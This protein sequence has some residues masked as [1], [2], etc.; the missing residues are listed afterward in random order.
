MVLY[1]MEA[2]IFYILKLK[3]EVGQR[4]LLSAGKSKE[5]KG[6]K[7]NQ[8]INKK[9]G[10]IFILF[11]WLFAESVMHLDKKDKKSKDIEVP[12][13]SAIA[14]RENR[15]FSF[16]PQER[17]QESSSCFF[18]RE[19]E[20]LV[21]TTRVYSEDPGGQAEPSISK[22]NNLYL[23]VCWDNQFQGLG[24]SIEAVRVTFSGVLIDSG[25]ITIAEGIDGHSGFGTS[26]ASEFDGNKF[27]VVWDDDDGSGYNIYGKR[28][29]ENGV[30]IDTVRIP[31]STSSGNQISPSISFNGTNYFIVW[32]D[33]R[34]SPTG[35]DIYGT[36]VDTLGNVLEPDGILIYDGTGN[37][38]TPSIAYGDMNYLVVWN[39]QNDI[40]GVRMTSQGVVLDTI[41][42][43]SAP[44][45][46]R[47]PCV[48]FNQGI[49]FV[50]WQRGDDIYGARVRA[51]GT[52]L[53]PGGFPIS[54]ATNS[55]VSP[56]VFS[57]AENFFV[58]WSDTRSQIS[59]PDIYGA[60]V[61][62]LG[63]VLDTDGILI[64]NRNYNKSGNV[65]I[66]CYDT[67]YFVAWN[68]LDMYNL[69]NAMDIFAT[70]VTTSGNV[71]DPQGIDLSYKCNTQSQP[72]IACAGNSYLT[73]WEDFRKN[74]QWDI[75]AMRV[76]SQGNLVDTT[77]FPVCN[78]NSYQLNPAICF[79]GTNYFATWMDYRNSF[80]YHI[81]GARISQDGTVIDP[82]GF[83]I[84]SDNKDLWYPSSAFGN[85]NYLV[86][87]DNSEDI[88]P[89]L[90]A[91][92]SGALVDTI[93]GVI[94]TFQIS[95]APYNE[96]SA[97]VAFDNSN[98]FVVWQQ[99]DGSQFDIYGARVSEQGVLLD[100]G[101]ILI[102]SR[103]GH[104]GFPMV[105]FDGQNYLVVWTGE[106]GQSWNIYGA[107]V[108]PDGAVL[109]PDGFVIS[110]E[111]FD[112]YL[113]DIGFLS[114]FG[115]YLVCWED[116]RNGD[117]DIYAAKINVDGVVEATFLFSQ[118]LR[119]QLYPTLSNSVQ[120]N[121]T[122]IVWSNYTPTPYGTERIWGKLY[123]ETAVDEERSEIVLKSLNI[124]PTHFTSQTNFVLS[125]PCKIDYR[126]KFYDI[127]GRLID[128][129]I[130]KA[131]VSEFHWKTEVLCT[132]IY[133]LKIEVNNNEEKIY[134]LVKMK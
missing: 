18:L 105:S 4:K 128:S 111:S 123:S 97:D 90:P 21:D 107:R 98:F 93:G 59:Y 69:L 13:Y 11:T 106:D 81:F 73:I 116:W 85:E 113:P 39:D 50:V 108:R 47:L 83:F 20:F 131:G 44:E 87:Y 45:T 22:G 68:F 120:N 70:R 41:Q 67:T 110:D 15:F 61:D 58:C 78:C 19:G 77:S 46:E 96:F 27:L 64:F 40:K 82:N 52:I 134:K 24:E 117:A 57:D 104:E 88:W 2:Y 125:I 91:E 71:L 121:K 7:M 124:Y 62:T 9:A 5:Q 65:S 1:S 14:Q 99:S 74:T 32:H 80:T 86:V 17:N 3:R 6:D 75:Y 92:I 54:T 35:V 16:L 89:S 115:Y 8:N 72:S 112:E 94:T 38:I 33:S 95:S 127:T 130:L 109:D 60:R 37:Q 126:L 102:S 103:P 84:D 55:Q 133:F 100:P 31:I 53:D 42:I 79:N 49:Y 26:L 43:A 25:G 12:K 129:F 63:N 51:D 132:G 66:S 10:I 36:R 56:D 101:G 76:S 119:D 34:N 23:V 29:D 28:I 30:V 48:C 122:L 114:S 118:Q